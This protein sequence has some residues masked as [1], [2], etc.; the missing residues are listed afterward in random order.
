MGGCVYAA[1][2]AVA[3]VAALAVLLT[4]MR[5]DLAGEDGEVAPQVLART[6]MNTLVVF[7]TPC[8]F[9][10]ITMLRP[11]NGPPGI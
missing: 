11:R 6:S 8:S 7:L 3:V 1:S 5:S 9:C 10:T 2:A 4:A